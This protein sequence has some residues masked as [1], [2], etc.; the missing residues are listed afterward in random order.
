M[1]QRIKIN[2]EETLLLSQKISKSNQEIT[3]EFRS[4]FKK[5]NNLKNSWNGKAASKVLSDFENLYKLSSSRE[6]ILQNC[7]EMLR[8]NV[9]EGGEVVETHNIKLADAFQ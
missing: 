5:V 8:R 3:G 9:I 6:I 1:V 2:T 4:L 7:S